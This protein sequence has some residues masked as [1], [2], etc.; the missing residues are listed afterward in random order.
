MK[1]FILYLVLVLSSLTINGCVVV[2]YPEGYHSWPEERRIEWRR[3][4]HK[5]WYER[6]DDHHDRRDHPGVHH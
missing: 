3:H 5:H 6:Y 2:A 4:H 1:R